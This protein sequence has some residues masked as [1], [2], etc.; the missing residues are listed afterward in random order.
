MSRKNRG[1]PDLPEVY[2]AELVP[3]CRRLV[4]RIRYRE[5]G[6]FG[7]ACRTCVLDPAECRLYAP[8]AAGP[9]APR[10]LEE[11]LSWLVLPHGRPVVVRLGR[12]AGKTTS[13]RF[14]LQTPPANPQ[15]VRS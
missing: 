9:D 7:L 4:I 13:A 6:R 14:A 8:D 10:T 12:D 11:I 1:T 2:A 15:E 5:C 3:G